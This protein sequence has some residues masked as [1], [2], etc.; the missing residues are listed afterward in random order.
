[1]SHDALKRLL[2]LQTLIKVSDREGATIG[3]V[4]GGISSQT[5]THKLQTLAD[6]LKQS[7]VGDPLVSQ[8]EWL[9]AKKALVV[10]DES[11]EDDMID[12]FSAVRMDDED[13]GDVRDSGDVGGFEDSSEKKITPEHVRGE[14]YEILCGILFH[15]KMQSDF[16]LLDYHADPQPGDSEQ[17]YADLPPSR[18]Q[19]RGGLQERV[20]RVKAVF[21]SER[22]FDGR[23]ALRWYDNRNTWEADGTAYLDDLANYLRSRTEGI[24]GAEELIENFTT[25]LRRYVQEDQGFDILVELQEVDGGDR[26]LILAQCKYRSSPRAEVDMAPYVA[27]YHDVVFALDRVNGLTPTERPMLMPLFWMSTV[28]KADAMN[29]FGNLRSAGKIFF[30][31]NTALGLDAPLVNLVP[32][33]SSFCKQWLE[34]YR[35]ES[36]GAFPYTRREPR[37]PMQHQ[38]HAMTAVYKH[39]IES[40]KSAEGVSPPASVIMATGSGKTLTSLLAVRQLEEAKDS[41]VNPS[42]IVR[43]IGASL[44]FSPMTRLV[45]QNAHDWL[46]EEL[47]I[48]GEAFD[49]IYYCVCSIRKEAMM[50][51][52]SSGCSLRIIPLADLPVVIQRNC[53][54]KS[55]NRCRFFTTYQAGEALRIVCRKINLDDGL[56]PSAPLFGIKLLDE[57]H[58]AVGRGTKSHGAGLLIPSLITLSFT[59]TARYSWYHLTK[60]FPLFFG[61]AQMN[62]KVNFS[63]LD[64]RYVFPQVDAEA[65][66]NARIN[67][68]QLYTDMQWEAAD[69]IDSNWLWHEADAGPGGAEL[70]KEEPMYDW[71]FFQQAADDLETPI[72]VFFVKDTPLTDSG[73]Q[74]FLHH[75]KPCYDIVLDQSRPAYYGV[76]P[77][78]ESTFAI[79][80]QTEAW[81]VNSSMK[82]LFEP[83]C[84]SPNPKGLSLNDMSGLGVNNRIGRVVFKLSYRE[85]FEDNSLV[86]PSLIT[87]GSKTL[88]HDRI[89][90]YKRCLDEVFTSKGV[91]LDPSRAEWNLTIGEGQSSSGKAH[92]FRSMKLLCDC[93]VERDNIRKVLVFCT[94]TDESKKCRAILESM[95]KARAGSE[96]PGANV[97]V[98]TDII[99]SSESMDG[100]IIDIMPYEKQ[101]L[102]LNRFCESP[103]KAVLFNVK[104]ISIGVDLPS[105]DTVMIL[106]PS[107]SQADIT[108]KIGRCL[109]VDRRNPHKVATVIVP[110]WADDLVADTSSEPDPDGDMWRAPCR[111]SFEDSFLLIKRVLDAMDDESIKMISSFQACL[112][113]L[114]AEEDS[115]KKAG[116]AEKSSTIR[117]LLTELRGNIP[118]NACPVFDESFSNL[119]LDVW[120]PI[121][122]ICGPMALTRTVQIDTEDSKKEDI[123]HLYV[124]VAFVAFCH[125]KHLQPLGSDG[126]KSFLWYKSKAPFDPKNDSPHIKFEDGHEHVDQILNLF[127][128]VDSVDGCNG[129]E[130]LKDARKSKDAQNHRKC[131]NLHTSFHS[132]YPNEEKR[133]E[134]VDKFLARLKKD[135]SDGVNAHAHAIECFCASS[136]E[137]TGCY[138]HQS[139]KLPEILKV[140]GSYNFEDHFANEFKTFVVSPDQGLHSPTKKWLA[141]NKNKGKTPNSKQSKGST[142][143]GSSI[144]KRQ[145]SL[146]LGSPV[147]A[148]QGEDREREVE[149]EADMGSLT[150]DNSTQPSCGRKLDMDFV[151]LTSI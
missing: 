74:P 25:S 81:G 145:R 31:G 18:E 51:T 4:I 151:D 139:H 53:Q 93:L 6:E 67:T 89:F 143:G 50:W 7:L 109:R 92:H 32:N 57:A 75:G 61:D 101:Q 62:E 20:C 112:K 13:A 36:K 58:W 120:R 56:L 68:D 79:N 94:N 121:E 85:C 34:N 8:L 132:K 54:K 17:E 86:R 66:A 65:I 72:V 38:K 59:A 144:K 45:I 124:F 46:G 88:S 27:K 47:A 49:K 91:V 114:P 26:H 14:A 73:G 141:A 99:Y 135:I 44:H 42:S 1:M 149:V 102:A 122:P 147:L 3:D 12:N 127:G 108:Q 148:V 137:L 133:A 69:V 104:L 15:C 138:C 84:S 100:E 130:R 125:H 140:E 78:E 82:K 106:N 117:K 63:E 55:L 39:F 123:C 76:V 60:I 21:M 16:L 118:S 98:H 52:V 96:H 111:H 95:L 71:R 9:A 126:G 87:L 29:Y 83:A 41:S 80:H 97:E 90:G 2:A 40:N 37:Q 23:E 24:Q 128:F 35:N 136:R 30:Y 28:L 77:H 48:D 64:S 11:A 146:S 134:Y 5:S 19:R 142:S 43:Q 150:L 103:G 22:Q 115:A 119:V 70:D 131:E 110:M 10:L 129:L 113:R 107:K 105:I 116:Q 33:V